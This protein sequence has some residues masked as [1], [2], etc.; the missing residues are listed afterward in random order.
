MKK[1]PRLEVHTSDLGFSFCVR[2][3]SKSMIAGMNK[4]GKYGVELKFSVKSMDVMKVM[5]KSDSKSS[6]DALKGTMAQIKGEDYTDL[7]A[8]ASDV[9]ETNTIMLDEYMKSENQSVSFK[10]LVEANHYTV[11]CGIENTFCA[12]NCSDRHICK[13]AREDRQGRCTHRT[14]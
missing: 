6:N 10:R 11:P 3:G 8:D 1:D 4:S 13:A 5:V 7:Q 12:N 2:D 9:K 14:L